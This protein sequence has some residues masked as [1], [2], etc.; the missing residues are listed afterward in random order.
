MID[1][2]IDAACWLSVLSIFLYCWLF[3]G[4]AQK[5]ASSSG[6]VEKSKD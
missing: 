1:N 5:G 3:D 6:R 4:D 2:W